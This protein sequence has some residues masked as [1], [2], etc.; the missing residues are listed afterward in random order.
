MGAYCSHP[1]TGEYENLSNCTHTRFHVD[2]STITLHIRQ[3]STES[4]I[5]S[6]KKRIC[7]VQFPYYQLADAVCLNCN[8]L[9]PVESD[10]CTTWQDG[11]RTKVETTK[12]IKV[13]PMS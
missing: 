2:E 10:Y 9:I 3:K 6:D 7:G 4:F 13:Q 8:A 12:W 5:F 1:N 11:G